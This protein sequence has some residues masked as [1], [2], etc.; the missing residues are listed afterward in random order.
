ME[1]QSCARM[2]CE[3]LDRL[4]LAEDSDQT[5]QLVRIRWVVSHV[6]DYHFCETTQEDANQHRKCKSCPWDSVSLE[7][8]WSTSWA[9]SQL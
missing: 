8:D 7:H 6:G 9:R 2:D 4:Q 3:H 5:A 1:M